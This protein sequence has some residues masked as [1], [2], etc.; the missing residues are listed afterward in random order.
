MAVDAGSIIYTV[1]ADTA[2]LLAAEKEVKKANKSFFESFGGTTKIIKPMNDEIA[3]AEA[4][5]KAMNKEVVRSEGRFKK[6]TKSFKLQKNSAQ[7]LGFQ[8]QDVA[9]QLQGG[10]SAAVVLGQQGSQLAGV[11]GPG[12]ALLGA[13]IA[14]SAA[15]GG[16]LL[17]VLFSTKDEF[18]DLDATVEG[19][20]GTLDKFELRKINKAIEG[21]E[22]VVAGLAR[23][24]DEVSN[25]APEA[26][27]KIDRWL[28]SN[29]EIRKFQKKSTEDSVKESVEAF[30][31]KADAELKLSALIKKMLEIRDRIDGEDKKREEKAKSRKAASSKE[32]LRLEQEA[33]KKLQ[34]QRQLSGAVATLATENEKIRKG[35]EDRNAIIQQQTEAGSDLQRELTTRNAEF[36]VSQQQA[37]ND[38]EI[39]LEQSKQDQLA[40]IRRT[41]N[42]AFIAEQLN[43]SAQTAAR[44]IELSEAAS[45]P[46]E[47]LRS[48]WTGAML[49]VG[50]SI[51]DT[52][53][54]AI[55]QGED[56]SQT[57]KGVAQS[58]LADLI[59]SLIKVGVR[60]LVN[61]AIGTAGLAAASAASVAAGSVTATAW[62]PAAALASL[63]SF[64]AN[65]A[66]AAAGIASTV[67]LSQGL[68]LGGGR[69][70][71][72]PVGPGRAFP[73]AEDGRPEIL[74][75]G[76]RQFLIPG[77]RGDVTS[78]KDMRGG[79]APS[80]NINFNVQ[81]EMPGAGFEVRGVRQE[82]S[83][84]TINAIVS[85]IRTGN[86]PI[87]RALTESTSVTRKTQ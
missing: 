66:P 31:K 55:V 2:P 14:I 33:A 44:L 9:V 46:A 25:K 10:T 27:S 42:E 54:Q 83:E 45:R 35:F 72:G 7:Q 29:E 3:K 4:R 75:Q 58:F 37:L 56:L 13:V 30:D 51:G 71:G 86:G 65:A 34:G 87:T 69:L 57:I 78:N 76:N 70:N 50:D 18:K 43:V 28:N 20:I 32:E 49:D 63:A 79:G 84:V 80:I 26:L 81:N 39:K 47:E 12:G 5:M 82:G 16:S 19:F 15:I 11:L 41:A 77:A 36:F 40:G 64:G 62:A 1:D 52:L 6:L 74:T 24:Y 48:S 60:M 68:A 22:K 61:Q 67:A 73:V 8:L 23:A 85:D 21:Q 59:G 38:K 17:P 53:G